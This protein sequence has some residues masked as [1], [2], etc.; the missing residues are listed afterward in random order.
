MTEVMRGALTYCVDRV[1][2]QADCILYLKVVS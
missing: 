2:I 1:A